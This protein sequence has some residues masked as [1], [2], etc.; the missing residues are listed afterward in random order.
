M[1]LL[2]GFEQ[3]LARQDDSLLERL[4][5][6][7]FLQLQKAPRSYRHPWHLGTVASVDGRQARA[8]VVVLQAVQT[9]DLLLRFHTDCRAN[10]VDQLRNSPGVEWLF[11]QPA[12]RI[13]LRLTCQANVLTSG[14]DWEEAWQKTV[15]QS[16][17]CYLAPLPPAT[18]VSGPSVNLPAGMEQRHPT[19]E[20]SEAGRENFA[21]VLCQVQTID[22]MF[23]HHNGHLRCLIDHQNGQWHTAWATP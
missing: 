6:R 12:S 8:R 13:Q 9:P 20:E 10:K 21:I 17:R 3:E 7:I 16:R 15:L 19:A 2:S 23:L 22:W 11:Y 5:S 18:R 14:P 4:R 1:S